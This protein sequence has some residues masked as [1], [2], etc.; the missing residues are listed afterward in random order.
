M[1]QSDRGK[2]FLGKA[3]QQVLKTNHI[4]YR[5]IF[6]L[7]QAAVFE[8]YIYQIKM[9]LYFVKVFHATL[10]GLESQVFLNKFLKLFKN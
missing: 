9:K 6:G 3:T 2:E 4:V 8:H 10:P 1:L 5:P 7:H